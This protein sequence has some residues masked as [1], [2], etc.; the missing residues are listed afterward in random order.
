MTM[1]YG[2]TPHQMFHVANVMNIVVICCDR[3]AC[4]VDIHK[5]KVIEM[6][7]YSPDWKHVLVVISI[8]HC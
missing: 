6:H 3:N 2:T 1:G 7:T 4:A 8:M 5:L